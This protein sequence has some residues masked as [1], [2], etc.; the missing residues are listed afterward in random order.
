[1]EIMTDSSRLAA[2]HGKLTGDNYP[3]KEG[4]IYKKRDAFCLETQHFPNSVNQ[5]QFPSPIYPANQEF[6]S[7]TSFKFFVF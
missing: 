5:S 2:L 7:R 3:G 6:N 4:A 1:M